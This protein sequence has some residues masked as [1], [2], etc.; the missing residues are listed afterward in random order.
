MSFSLTS[1]DTRYIL[2]EFMCDLGYDMDV[3]GVR[4]LQAALGTPAER[5]W[6]GSIA[7]LG[8]FPSEKR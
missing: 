6:A 7:S 3:D 1:P 2:V 4:Y 5:T 8:D